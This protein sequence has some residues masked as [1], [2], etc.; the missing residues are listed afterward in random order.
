MSLENGIK[1]VFRRA[2]YHFLDKFNISLY[3]ITKLSIYPYIYPEYI[4]FDQMPPRRTH[5]VIKMIY[6]SLEYL[7]YSTFKLLAEH[8]THEFLYRPKLARCKK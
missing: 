4:L 1:L 3:K 5:N 7:H 6:A 2:Y 8:K